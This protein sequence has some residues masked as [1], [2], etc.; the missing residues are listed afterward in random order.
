MF[1]VHKDLLCDQSR[2][3]AIRFNEEW[4][5]EQPKDTTIELEN[6]DPADFRYVIQWLYSDELNCRVTCL[7]EASNDP[8]NVY[9]VSTSMRVY[10]IADYL[11]IDN[12]MNDIADKEV[13]YIKHN[14]VI[15]TGNMISYFHD[16]SLMH[17]CY[18]QLCL[19]HFVRTLHAGECGTGSIFDEGL[20][21]LVRYPEA[22]RHILKKLHEYSQEPRDSMHEEGTMCKYHIHSTD[23]KE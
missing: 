17:T 9:N 15:F 12:S 14:L 16:L 13:V 23:E 7:E 1:N 22:M 6:V 5:S 10:Q 3:F 2:D 4:S 8:I 11:M 20:D 18:Y 21:S 19:H